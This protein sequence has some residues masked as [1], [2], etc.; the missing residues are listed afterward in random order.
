[1]PKHAPEKTTYAEKY[2]D[3][4]YEYRIVTLSEA[5]FKR[6][7]QSYRDYYTAD[8]AQ[9]LHDES[10]YLQEYEQRREAERAH[11]AAAQASI[12]TFES[13]HEENKVEREEG[14]KQRLL[15]EDEWRALDLRMSMGWHHFMVYQ[16]EPHVLL[17]RRQLGTNPRT[18]LVGVV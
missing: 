18:G 7:P 2:D 4:T 8:N 9:R 14:L 16:P 3:G 13:S 17:F 1:M 11:Q 10:V 12:F 15:T 6:L 5:D